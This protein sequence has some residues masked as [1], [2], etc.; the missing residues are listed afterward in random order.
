MTHRIYRCR[1]NH[2]MSTLKHYTTDFITTHAQSLVNL[3]M[4]EA[5]LYGRKFYRGLV[6]ISRVEDERQDAL[7]RLRSS[8][9][10]TVRDAAN[11]LVAHD[12]NFRWF[13]YLTQSPMSHI[14]L[15]ARHSSI[16]REV[17]A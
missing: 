7:R 3:A 16:S 15:V 8:R 11:R 6:K 10:A 14:E 1:E 13:R 12:G 9:S 5:D 4:L 2:T 17:L